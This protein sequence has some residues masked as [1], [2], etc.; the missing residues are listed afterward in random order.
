[1]IVEDKQIIMYSQTTWPPCHQ[2][3]AWL[4]DQNIPVD[5]RDIR[6]NDQYV[7]ELIKMG[8]QMTPTFVIGKQVLIGF[9]PQKLLEAWKSYIG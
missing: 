2:A 3:K 7:D 9:D 5:I 1:M 6:Q 8:S 4:S